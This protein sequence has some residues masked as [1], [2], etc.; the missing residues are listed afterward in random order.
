M[1]KD[2]GNL[3]EF[4]WG[5]DNLLSSFLWN[6]F[7]LHLLFS[8]AKP[9]S[10]RDS[11]SPVNLFSIDSSP[12]TKCVKSF[13]VIE[14]QT[15]GTFSDFPGYFFKSFLLYIGLYLINNVVIVPL[16]STWD[17]PGYFLYKDTAG[18]WS[19]LLTTATTSTWIHTFNPLFQ[20]ALNVSC[21]LD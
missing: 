19:G 4:K 6:Y 12:A 9:L 8:V 14:T 5:I 13:P 18:P 7:C 15:L 21:I 20:G 11:F 17:Y 3:I 10:Q 1:F 16:L 2:W